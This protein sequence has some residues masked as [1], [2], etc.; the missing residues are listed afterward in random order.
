[1]ARRQIESQLY[2]EVVDS[3]FR[4]LERGT[5]EINEIYDAV[6]REYGNLCDDEYKCNHR[7]NDGLGQPEWKHVVRGALNRCKIIYDGI[8][9]SGRRGYWI[10]S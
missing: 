8:V 1:M 6:K 4:F 3:G 9:F 7:Q 5:R 10:F 2:R